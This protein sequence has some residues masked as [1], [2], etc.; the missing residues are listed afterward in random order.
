MSNEEDRRPK[1][2]PNPNPNPNSHPGALSLGS[3]Q[4]DGDGEQLRQQVLSNRQALL[5][6]LSNNQPGNRGQVQE[7]PS[8]PSSNATPAQSA[9]LTMNQVVEIV[10]D[11]LQKN[12][13]EA[14][15]TLAGS[16]AQLNCQKPQGVQERPHPNTGQTVPWMRG[17]VSLPNYSLVVDADVNRILIFI[18]PSEFLLGFDPNSDL[19]TPHLSITHGVSAGQAGWFLQETPIGAVM[20]PEIARQLLR[21]LIGVARGQLDPKQPFTYGGGGAAPANP[22]ALPREA[23]PAPVN[24][25]TNA[26]VVPPA[27]AVPTAPG[28]VRAPAQESAVPSPSPSAPP[29]YS[30]GGPTRSQRVK[31]L[32]VGALDE[33]RSEPIHFMPKPAPKN[34]AGLA[35]VAPGSAAPPGAGPPVN[36]SVMPPKDASAPEGRQGMKETNEFA[37]LSELISREKSLTRDN[38]TQAESQKP[39]PSAP[40]ISPVRSAADNRW[41]RPESG[42]SMP[43][44]PGQQKPPGMQSS[45]P[46][47]QVSPPV[48]PGASNPSNN[49]TN[50]PS[51]PS[52]PPQP[53]VATEEGVGTM[54]GLEAPPPESTL[55]PAPASVPEQAPPAIHTPPPVPSLPPSSSSPIPDMDGAD[56]SSTA[57]TIPAQETSSPPDFS[58]EPA[59]SSPPVPPGETFPGSISIPDSGFEPLAEIE[60][61][62]SP[63]AG[64]DTQSTEAQQESVSPLG[65]LLPPSTG[66]SGGIPEISLD[67]LK[68]VEPA[69]PNEIEQEGSDSLSGSLKSLISSDREE[70]VSKLPVTE[71]VTEPESFPEPVSEAVSRPSGSLQALL[72][73]EDEVIE[74]VEEVAAPV[75]VAAVPDSGNVSRLVA[76]TEKHLSDGCRDLLSNVEKALASLKSAGV[77]AMQNDNIEQVTEIMNH[78]KRLKALKDKLSALSDEF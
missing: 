40:Q 56:I 6:N 59:F 36:P 4:S 38:T 47:A 16:D 72:S 19:F 45:P 64:P 7:M 24:S 74:P 49:P 20:L 32:M 76:E 18:V 50:S 42:S 48:P 21:N 62:P 22:A 15:K 39:T 31:Q 43:V 55:E 70:A 51:L 78:T 69:A 14:N 27:S 8:E 17:N 46:N 66:D 23:P 68:K 5:N 11:T 67:S 3:T 13:V 57:S 34:G 1:S 63:P 28:A 58:Q 30:G 10:F 35:A 73:A 44:P 25:V 54:P 77:E 53:P 37:M 52:P 26:P 12:C 60:A 41:Q 2:N 61:E 75:Q 71:P 29:G 33:P 65:S 9:S